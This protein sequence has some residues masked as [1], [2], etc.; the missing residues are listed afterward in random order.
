[1]RAFVT[2]ATGFVGSHL[3]ETLAAR[4]HDVVALARRRD[5]HETLEKIGVRPVSGSLENER[6][7]ETALANVEVVFHV[8]GVTDARNEAEF[9]AVNDTGTRKL[10]DATRRTAHGLRRFV[11]VSS[12]AAV[13]PSP[14]GKPL[15]E[16]S[17]P[18]PITSYGR[19]KLAGELAVR[20]SGL[21]WTV[22][23][24]P[25]VYG[26]R[27]KAFLKLFQLTRTGLAPVFGGG[28]QE[29]SLVFVGDLVALLVSAGE[30]EAAAG[31]VFHAA[32]REIV[33]SRDV[34]RAAG[35]AM[36]KRPVVLPVPGLVASAVVGVIERV[37]A[38]T[39]QRTVLTTERLAEFLAPS[40]L[41]DVEKAERLLGWKAATSLSEG[42]KETGEWYRANGWL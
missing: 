6:S 42:M 28:T 1:M 20:G 15:R 9:L 41:L 22:V 32:H 34:S 25:A 8:A 31:Q 36:G 39:G 24:P 33:Q 19:S 2:G 10:L 21:P 12:Q 14:R 27:D 5:Q 23:R 35:A 7:L 17:E 18:R 16:E 40:W 29:L 4:G 13:G 30:H 26:P 11:H 37:A 3:A 38:A